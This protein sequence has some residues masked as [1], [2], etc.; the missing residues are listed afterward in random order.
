MVAGLLNDG[1]LAPPRA[2]GNVRCAQ[3]R[4]RHTYPSVLTAI[5]SGFRAESRVIATRVP[6][7]PGTDAVP[8]TAILSVPPWMWGGD[9]SAF[10]EQTDRGEGHWQ[11]EQCA[12]RAPCDSRVRGR[13]T[14]SACCPGSFIGTSSL[15][16]RYSP[17]AGTGWVFRARG[18]RGRR[19]RGWL[20]RTGGIW[21]VGFPAGSAWGRYRANGQYRC[22]EQGP[23]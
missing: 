15:V 18:W 13:L 9:P 2:P 17:L 8:A 20:R 3:R 14:V 21:C 16:L 7:V 22:A 19:G 4:N 1:A 10:F 23:R 6:R 12:A 11:P 5:C